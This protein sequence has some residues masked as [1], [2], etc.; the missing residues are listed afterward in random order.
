ME[1]VFKQTEMLERIKIDRENLKNLSFA[2][3]LA[4]QRIIPPP[5]PQQM[6]KYINYQN[7]ESL[8]VGLK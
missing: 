1:G 5:P 6:D 3:D 4:L 7:S 8:K 2:D